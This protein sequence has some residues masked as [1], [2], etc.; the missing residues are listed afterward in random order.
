MGLGVLGLYRR[1]LTTR[2]AA[3]FSSIVNFR[4]IATA[5]MAFIG[6]TGK[7]MP[8]ATPV[9]IFAVPVPSKVAGREMD[10]VITR[11]V[12]SGRR[13]PR[14]PKDPDSS[15]IGSDLNVSTLCR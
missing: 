2:P 10:L 14:S 15:A 1:E 6:C 5:A 8:K 12:I 13:V 7:G 11:A 4:A 9:S 3:A